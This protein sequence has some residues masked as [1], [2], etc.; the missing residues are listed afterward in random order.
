LP[1]CFHVLVTSSEH[2]RPCHGAYTYRLVRVFVKSE[3]H[4][5]TNYFCASISSHLVQWYS[6]CDTRTPWDT[7]NHIRWYTKF[8]RKKML[9]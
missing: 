2:P 7:L 8:E 5:S 6:T 1:V 9:W 4:G 3:H